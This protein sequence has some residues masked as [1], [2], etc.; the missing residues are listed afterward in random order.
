M[1]RLRKKTNNRPNQLHLLTVKQISR[2]V[3]GNRAEI[4]IWIIGLVLVTFLIANINSFIF[5]SDFFNASEIEIIDKYPGKIEYPLARI[6]DTSNIFKINLRKIAE[7]LEGEYA[8]I[9]K[10][11]VRRVLP[12]KL[13]IEVLRRRPIAQIAV[14]PNSGKNTLPNFFSVN[15]DGYILSG[16]GEKPN[17]KLPI[18][19]GSGIKFDEVEI[20]RCYRHLNLK[21]AIALLRELERRG[22][23]ERYPVS[24][25]D[26][27][28]PQ[29]ISF[30]IYKN[31]EVK[32]GVRDWQKKIENLT[33]IL[34]NI[35]LN[36]SQ[37]YYLDLRFKD[38]VFGEKK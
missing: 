31:L 11:I 30:H 26:L 3:K 17:S 22:F 20:G 38:F 13:V 5:A 1:R 4:T 37:N 2:A 9:Q 34:K 24:K 27:N 10:A 18:I 21:I 29:Y 14:C 8:D 35:D 25:I 23:L 7:N 16:T 32:I 12:N 15:E 36:Y 33:G 28:N 19:Y 6:Q